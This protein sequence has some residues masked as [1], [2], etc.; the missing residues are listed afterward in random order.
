MLGYK[1]YQLTNGANAPGNK[2]KYFAIFVLFTLS[3][4]YL[5][6][7][8]KLYVHS[9]VYD[10]S[11]IKMDAKIKVRRTSAVAEELL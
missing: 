7:V 4:I 6:F 9:R 10:P 5:L 2:V 11:N 8:L 3:H 1:A